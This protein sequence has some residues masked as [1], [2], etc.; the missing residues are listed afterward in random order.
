MKKI[1]ILVPCYNEEK[2]LP[3]LHERLAAMMDGM[4]QYEWEVLLVN[5]GSRDATMEVARSLRAADDRVCYIDLS[6]NF[7]KERAMLAGFD[8]ATGDCMVIMDA[9]LQHPPEVI[10]EMIKNWEEGW[11]DVYARRNTR[12]KES[13]LRRKL[14]M[15]YYRLLQST[16]RTDVLQN[17][18]DFRLIDRKCI[19]AIKQMRECERYTKGLFSWIGFRKKEI[20]FDQQ[21][22]VAGKS[23]FGMFKLA[24]LA[25]QG[26]TS[27]TTAPLRLATVMGFVVSIVALLY[28]VY[29]FVKTLIYGDPVAGYP[30]LII[31]ILFMGGVQL[32]SL[33]I[34]GE[35]LARIFNE[36]KDRPVYIVRDKEGV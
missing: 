28:M 25:I 5:D 16:T 1:T 24:S 20:T 31:V 9:D 10:P 27:F 19:D 7:G 34:I 17:V 21:D 33:G 23:S 11:E 13:W 36:S 2:S 29:V 22:R 26:I 30:T 18:G 14:T 6:R 8:Y 12:G 32:I 35:Y 3:M 4:P 15:S